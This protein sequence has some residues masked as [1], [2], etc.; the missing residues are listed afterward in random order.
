MGER[1]AV[2]K[3]KESKMNNQKQTGHGQRN[4]ENLTIAIKSLLI[5]KPTT[6]RSR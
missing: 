3:I 5:Q 1:K 4:A 2:S 6:L